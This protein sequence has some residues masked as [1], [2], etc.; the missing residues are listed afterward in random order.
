MSGEEHE[1]SAPKCH[2]S[3]QASG[4]QPERINEFE[5][6]P[7]YQ[8]LRKGKVTDRMPSTCVNSHAE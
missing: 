4:P 5:T 6:P 7:Y 1:L 2:P 8:R 3:E